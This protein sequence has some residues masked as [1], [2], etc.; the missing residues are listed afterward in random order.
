MATLLNVSSRTANP[1][2]AGG[3][4]VS[5]TLLI[6]QLTPECFTGHAL[7]NLRIKLESLASGATTNITTTTMGSSSRQGSAK[8][9]CIH[10]FIPLPS[11]ARVM[12][13]MRRETDALRIKLAFDRANWSGQE[14][15]VYFGEHTSLEEKK[16]TLLGVPDNDRLWL[17]SPPGSPPVD[18]ESTREDP[19]NLRTHADDLFAALNRVVEQQTRQREMQ[20]TAS[21]S[22]P[23]PIEA[24]TTIQLFDN[25]DKKNAG[26]HLGGN[27]QTLLPSSKVRLSCQEVTLP[28]IAVQNWDDPNGDDDDDMSA[29]T[30]SCTLAVPDLRASIAP[31]CH[32]T[33]VPMK[34]T[35]NNTS[36]LSGMNNNKP[37]SVIPPTSIT[38]TFMTENEQ[39][40]SDLPSP[41]VTDHA[42]VPFRTSIPPPPL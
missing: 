18:W 16:N 31:N 9:A 27:V 41:A 3:F 24:P 14:I 34:L 26:H 19:P 36:D 8:P 2:Q 12:V 35:T 33:A 10:K 39:A 23:S 40:A 21:L 38:F 13:V 42:S 1:V 37:S 7:E 6:T 22:L 11:F 4:T 15:R 28:A 30:G 20:A 5:N 29:V 17:I 25:S 32:A